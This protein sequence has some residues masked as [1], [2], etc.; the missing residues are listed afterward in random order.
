MF[1]REAHGRRR[2][3]VGRRGFSLLEIIVAVTIMAVMVGAAV[4]VTSKVLTHKARKA[5]KQELAL[6]SDALTD[7]AADTLALPASLEEL[8]VDPGVDGWSGPYLPGVLTDEI[9]QLPGY[10]VDAWSRAYELSSSGDV[11]TV[12]SSGEDNLAGSSQDIAVSIDITPIRREETLVRLQIINQAIRSY[13]AVH[14]DTAPLA[15]SWGTAFS[16]LVSSGYLPNSIDY[17]QDAWRDT[18][19]ADPPGQA[20]VVRAG[21]VNL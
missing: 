3:R 21:S 8:L 7:F 4:P 14:F 13:N 15:T 11:L 2:A 20:P 5:T 17:Q 1:G 16:Q 10:L 19:S 18:F 12:R 6:L 9:T